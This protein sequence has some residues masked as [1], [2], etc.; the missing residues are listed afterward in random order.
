MLKDKFL[1]IPNPD[2]A[3]KE[4]R[5]LYNRN[6]INSPWSTR[7]YLLSVEVEEH[8][9]FSRYV[10]LV[11]LTDLEVRFLLLVIV[12]VNYLMKYTQSASTGN[13]K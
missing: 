7:S 13:I 1:P 6:L 12:C 9:S 2:L 3:Q 4:Q 10:F 5:Q 8:S 11:D